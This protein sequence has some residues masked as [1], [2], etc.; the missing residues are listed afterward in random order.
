MTRPPY[1]RT[2]RLAELDSGAELFPR[3]LFKLAEITEAAGEEGPAREYDPEPPE[4]SQDPPAAD[5]PGDLFGDV[6]HSYT[7]SQAIEDGVL[8][9]LEG[10]HR[11]SAIEAA[12]H[13]AKHLGNTEAGR[14]LFD[15]FHDV[16]FTVPAFELV[17]WPILGDEDNDTSPAVWEAAWLT[18]R[19]QDLRG[20]LWD[21]LWLLAC[22]TRCASPLRELE[23]GLIFRLSCIVAR[24]QD[25]AS[26][27]K[28][29]ARR[30]RHTIALKAVLGLNDSGAA[31]LTIMLPEED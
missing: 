5:D 30:G 9:A 25:T 29:P 17:V 22:R 21:V 12:G 11:D 28:G 4:S 14:I 18:A 1:P 20:R 19:G 7:R 15:A 2:L 8:V 16:A 13:V 31:C 3:P 10:E 6:I 24:A 27:C 23:A 26:W